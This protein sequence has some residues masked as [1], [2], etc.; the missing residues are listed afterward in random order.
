MNSSAKLTPVVF[1]DRTWLGTVHER[2]LLERRSSA[3]LPKHVAP[4]STLVAAM[5]NHWHP[6]CYEAAVEMCDY[7]A[8]KQ[9][10]TVTLYEESDRCY[11]PYDGLGIM[12]NMAY[13]RAIREGYEYILYLD[14]DVQPNSGTLSTLLT[15]MVPIVTPIIT[16]ADG[17]D[18]GLQMPKMERNRGL[19][20]VNNVVLSCL[21]IYVPVFLPWATGGFW[22]SQIG[23]DE[24]YHFAKLLNTGHRPFVYTNE[25]VT[26]MAPPLFPF[27]GDADMR[28]FDFGKRRWR[29]PHD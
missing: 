18:H 14:N 23:A 13:M 19:A 5:G 25:V 10:Y 3:G 27:D 7:T 21:L 8:K 6:G 11:Q 16:F 15:C 2:E 17:Q 4:F 12:R 26:C 24:G 20:M 1:R 28:E 9:G 29:C 22:D